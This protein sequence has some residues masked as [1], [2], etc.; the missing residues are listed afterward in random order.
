MAV[1]E[2]GGPARA[3]YRSFT[4]RHEGGADDFARIEEVVTRR[5]SA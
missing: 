3:A 4:M 2:Q 1:F 5:F